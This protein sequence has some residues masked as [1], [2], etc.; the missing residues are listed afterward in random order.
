MSPLS[1]LANVLSVL[2]TR[3]FA[4]LENLDALGDSC[5]EARFACMEKRP[6]EFHWE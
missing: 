1:S 3:A 6:P 4:L 2:A 5:D